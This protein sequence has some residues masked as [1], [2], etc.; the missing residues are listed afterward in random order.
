MTHV[1]NNLEDIYL[2]ATLDTTL[3]EIENVNVVSI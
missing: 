1:F 2:N 3:K